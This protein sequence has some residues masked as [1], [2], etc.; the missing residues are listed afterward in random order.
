MPYVNTKL[1]LDRANKESYA[2]P[3]LN[4]NNLEFL[5][6]IIDAGVEERSPVI[7]ETSEGAIKYAGNGNVM[8]G[9]RLFVS[10]VRS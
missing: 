3:A 4:I 9:A 7:I 8:L 1:I 10:M 2:V 6:A 5:Q